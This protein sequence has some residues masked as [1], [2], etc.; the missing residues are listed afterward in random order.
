MIELEQLRINK[1]KVADIGFSSDE[2]S[3]LYFQARELLAILTRMYVKIYN[4]DDTAKIEAQES[5]RELIEL[6]NQWLDKASI[7]K[8]FE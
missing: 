6:S 2:Q 7:I 3:E 4:M 1:N 8:E 5:M